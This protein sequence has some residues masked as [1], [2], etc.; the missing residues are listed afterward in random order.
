MRTCARACPCV[1]VLCIAV[2]AF[3]VGVNQGGRRCL[4][5]P[6]W[7][8]FGPGVKMEESGQLPPRSHHRHTTRRHD[9]TEQ[10][11]MSM[12]QTDI[13][14]LTRF[15]IENTK[16]FPDAQDLEVLLASIQVNGCRGVC[17]WKS[18]QGSS[19]LSHLFT[20]CPWPMDVSTPP[21]PL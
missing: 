14:T 12:V 20:F 8:W 11:A 5:S 9:D 18:H 1:C 16:T 3:G 19:R 13:M 21:L 10:G 7:V 6:L 4:F 15:M 17:G 2:V